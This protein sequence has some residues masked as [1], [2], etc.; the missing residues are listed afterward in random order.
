M[1]G[2]D[3]ERRLAR[4]RY[5]RNLANRARQRE[6][7]RRRNAILG[8]VAGVVVVLG[9]TSA[10][11]ATLGFP[12]GDGQP[13]G[14]PTAAGDSSGC[15]YDRLPKERRNKYEKFVG[16]PSTPPK[17]KAD[18]KAKIDT[19]R[20]TIVMKLLN[21][22][23]PCTVNSFRFLVSQDFYADTKCHRL[24]TK[25]IHVLQC[26]DPSG[27]GRGGPGYT[28]EDE[29]LQGAS[30]PRGT[31]AMAK[32]SQPDSGG[33]QFFFV[34]EKGGLAP[35]YTP[36]ANVV[37][38]MEIIDKVAEAGTAAN[39]VAPKK[40]VVISDI[41]IVEYEETSSPSTHPGPSSAEHSPSPSSSEAGNPSES[42]SSR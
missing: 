26:G 34:Y 7:A 36:F 11:A 19:N 16:L 12:G 13:S 37:K 15:T 1:A 28:I 5:E 35:K 22:E 6:R 38:G 40:K 18:Y 32:T 29:N 42:A 27:T 24:V 39:G 2:K 30:Y 4:E 41:T 3:R 33:S 23:A 8:A 20:G 10:L 31:V 25:G 9:G 21:D 14:K 17:P